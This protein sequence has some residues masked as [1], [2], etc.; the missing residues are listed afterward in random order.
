MFA[1][2]FEGGRPDAVGALAV[3]LLAC[4]AQDPALIARAAE[5]VPLAPPESGAVSPGLAPAAETLSAA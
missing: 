3:A 4:C 2:E 1:K 5:V